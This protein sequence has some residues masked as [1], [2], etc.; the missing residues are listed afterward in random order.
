M[1]SN[2]SQLGNLTKPCKREPIFQYVSC[3]SFLA[4]AVVLT[5]YYMTSISSFIGDEREAHEKSFHN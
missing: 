4:I 3:G 5:E 1:T 2:D